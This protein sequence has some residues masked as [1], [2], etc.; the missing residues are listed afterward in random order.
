MLKDLERRQEILSSELRLAK[1]EAT[2]AKAELADL[3][4]RSGATSPRETSHPDAPTVASWAK[5]EAAPVVAA[6]SAPNFRLGVGGG[7]NDGTSTGLGFADASIALPLGDDLGAQ[8]DLIGGIAGSSSFVGAATHLF[9]RDPDRGAVGVYASFLHGTG[10][11]L[12]KNGV[13]AGAQ[14][15]K[16][17]VEGQLYLDQFTL[18]GI[19]GGQWDSLERNTGLFFDGRVAWYA[20]DNLKLNIGYAHDD[21]FTK[22]RELVGGI[23]YNIPFG[24]GTAAQ[25]FGEAGYDIERDQGVSF[26]L[27]LRFAFGSG[28]KPLVRRDREDN[29]PTYLRWDAANMP[30]ATRKLPSGPPGAPGSDGPTGPDGPAGPPGTPGTDGPSGP[31]GTPGAPGTDGPS[32]PPGTPGAPGTDGPSGPPGTPGAPGTDGP[33]GPPGTPGA[34]GTDGPSGPPGTP[35]APGTDGPSGPPGTPGAPGTDGPSGPPGTPGAPGSD[36]PSGPPGAPGTP[37]NDGPSGPPGVPGNDGPSGPPGPPGND[38]P[39]G[40][41]GAPGPPGPPGA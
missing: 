29:L 16:A 36:G 24:N 28:N 1:E 4:S 27:G 7:H 25:M 18:Q 35:G 21:G 8:V 22:R 2:K 20:D 39:P 12:G 19:V 26:L 17:G 5:V 9:H 10:N 37:G 23:D 11:Y 31:P 14:A 32:G 41:P 33:S 6:V 3:Q 34:P 40:F 15:V 13:V 30:D 38:G